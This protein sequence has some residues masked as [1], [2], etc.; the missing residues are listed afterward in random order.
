MLSKLFGRKAIFRI[1]TMA[2]CLMPVSVHAK[3]MDGLMLESVSTLNRGAWDVGFG[4]EYGSG[5][6]PVE[7]PFVSGTSKDALKVNVIH[8]PLEV[9]YGLTDRSEVGWEAGFESND[10]TTF[11]AGSNAAGTYFDGSGLQRVRMFGKWKMRP[12]L[13]WMAEVSSLGDN[14]L[15]SGADGFD[16]GVKFIYGPKLGAGRLMFNLG[17]LIKGGGSDFNDNGVTGSVEQYH[18]PILLG[19]GYVYPF[20]SH[21][22]GIFEF[23]ASTAPF[24]GGSGFKANDMLS[25]LAGFRYGWADRVFLHGGAGFGALP[26]SP[27]VAVRMGLSWLLGT[28]KTYAE[29]Q[30]ES[31]DYW[32]PTEEMQAKLRQEKEKAA[33]RPA[34]KTWAPP[35]EESVEDRIAAASAA[36]GR[37][38]Y[39]AASAHYE[40]AIYMKN[41]DPLLHYNLATTYFL[42]KRYVSAKPYYLNAI[43]LNPADVDSHL[44]LGYT[45]Y[46]LNEPASAA[47][48]WQ[49][50]LKLDPDNALAR[51][52]LN[53]LSAP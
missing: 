11:P 22:S 51:D 49:D 25:V 10:G 21:F 19:A 34:E 23:A 41:D 3:P 29:M 52:N 30:A 16:F 50:V 47:Q 36:F 17:L 38:D 26:G 7:G 31:S 33:R 15:V 5:A 8:A 9:R 39:A 37:R 40:A 1:W 43:R 4:V 6:E 35:K 44:Y 20:T 42:R 24:D 2:C 45:Y 32:S 48:E 53:S 13:S 28:V 18:N 14:T 46:Y 27:N 12:R